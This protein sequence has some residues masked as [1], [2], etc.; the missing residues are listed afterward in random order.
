[1]K[2]LMLIG[3]LCVWDQE[4]GYAAPD[5][6][7]NGNSVTTQIEELFAS[8]RGKDADF[9]NSIGDIAGKWIITLAPFVDEG[10][11]E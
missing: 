1:M 4:G 11:N 6:T 7:I 5:V 3:S 10:A 8:E 9:P 2:S